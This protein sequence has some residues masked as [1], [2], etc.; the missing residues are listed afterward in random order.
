MAMSNQGE[1]FATH[2]VNLSDDVISALDDIPRDRPCYVRLHSTPDDG[3][4]ADMV[5]E[6]LGQWTFHQG[7][8]GT[9]NLIFQFDSARLNVLWD[10]RINAMLGELFTGAV[11]DALEQSFGS[12]PP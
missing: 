7:R 3:Q 10:M 1:T 2:L 5:M 8:E 4:L 12:A 6:L 9:E 11:K